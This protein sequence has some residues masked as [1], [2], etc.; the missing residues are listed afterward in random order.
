MQI[1]RLTILG[2]SSRTFFDFSSDF[3]TLSFFILSD[4][5]YSHSEVELVVN[6]KS[7]VAYQKVGPDSRVGSASG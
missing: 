2:F 4:L 3:F 6:I 1:F 5:Y 7:V